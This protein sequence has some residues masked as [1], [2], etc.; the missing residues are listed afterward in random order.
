MIYNMCI[1]AISFIAVFN[2]TITVFLVRAKNKIYKQLKELDLQLEELE[3]LKTDDA[4]NY[5]NLKKYE[6]YINLDGL[7]TNKNRR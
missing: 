5:D 1:V 2:L 6:K 7:L 3:Q 4:Y